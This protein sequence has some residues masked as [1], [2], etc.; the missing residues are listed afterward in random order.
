MLVS[1]L[2]SVGTAP[3]AAE[4]I[5]LLLTS[6]YGVLIVPASPVMIYVKWLA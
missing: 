3:P 2:S 1:T 5:L 4:L 6:T